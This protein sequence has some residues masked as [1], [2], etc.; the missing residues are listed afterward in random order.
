MACSCPPSSA[1]RSHLVCKMAQS[2]W[3]DVFFI[4]GIFQ[5]IGNCGNP[6]VFRQV[7]MAELDEMRHLFPIDVKHILP[8]Q[9]FDSPCKDGR[10]W[11]EYDK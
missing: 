6:F 2:F 11:V 4:F 5:L 1:D 9:R 7:E 3:I 10:F 8:Y